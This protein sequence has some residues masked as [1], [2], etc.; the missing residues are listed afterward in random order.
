MSDGTLSPG[1]RLIKF[2]FR[3][4]FNILCALALVF[5]AFEA[6]VAQNDVTMYKMIMLGIVALWLFLFIAKSFFRIVVLLVIVGAIAGGWFYFM[7]RDKAACEEKGGFWN[8]NTMTCEE[9]IPLLDKISKFFKNI[10]K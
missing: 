3:N 5:C 7:G 9:K 4:P 2:I 8:K 6:Y 10:E 1:R